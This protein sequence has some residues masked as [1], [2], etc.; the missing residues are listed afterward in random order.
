MAHLT[1]GR[2]PDLGRRPGSTTE[3]TTF[4][5]IFSTTSRRDINQFSFVEGFRF[6]LLK[7]KSNKL[8][9]NLV[10]VFELTA[11][12]TLHFSVLTIWDLF[13]TRKARNAP[14]VY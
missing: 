10:M 13:M 4:K 3:I 9:S 2:D 8:S 11:D 12:K 1:L 5:N 14:K 6:L 7:L